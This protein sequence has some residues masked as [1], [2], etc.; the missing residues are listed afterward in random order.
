MKRPK[1]T[2]VGAGHVGTTT[3]HWCAAAELGDLVLVDTRNG[4]DIARGKALDL[5]HAAPIMR[6]DLSII[7]SGSYE[8]TVDSD[9][10]VITAGKPRT[11]GMSRDELL[12][13]NAKIVAFASRQVRDTS[14]EAIVIVVTNPLDT[15]TQQAL[16][17]TGF[18]PHRVIGQAGLLDTA[19]LRTYLAMELGVRVEDINAMLIGGHGDT[20]VPLTRCSSVGGIPVDQ[21]IK[22]NRLKQVVQ[23]TRDSGAE[24]VSLMKTGASCAAGAATMRMI[25][26]VIRDEKRLIPCSTYCDKEYGVGGYCVGVPVILGAQGVERIVEFDMTDEERAQFQKSVAATK[27]LVEKMTQLDL[28]SC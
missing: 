9:V 15:M 19:R 2:I 25:E 26:A 6:F 18:P 8:H 3:A 13:V 10:V 28:C 22:P 16:Q 21:L 4:G 23:R 20:M 24:L 5:I 14:P 17:T 12:E 11:P 1:I 7:G 27:R